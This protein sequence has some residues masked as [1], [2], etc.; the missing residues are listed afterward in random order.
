M[1]KTFAP[2]YRNIFMALLEEQI[3]NKNNNQPLVYFRFLDDIFMIWTH[4]IE[5]FTTTPR[6]FSKKKKRKLINSY[7]Y[8]NIMHIRRFGKV[9]EAV[10]GDC[11]YGVGGAGANRPRGR[12]HEYIYRNVY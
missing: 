7:F 9:M 4:G 11:L 3:L 5:K 10:P 8:A 6:G 12:L 2:F 1:G